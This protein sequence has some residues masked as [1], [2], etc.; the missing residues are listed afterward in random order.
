M[1]YAYEW[2]GKDN[3]FTI[4]RTRDT[5]R[6]CCLCLFGSSFL[7]TTNRCL[8][9]SFISYSSHQLWHA[10]FCLCSLL[11]S[12]SVNLGRLLC[13]VWFSLVWIGVWMIELSSAFLLTSLFDILLGLP[14]WWCCQNGG[15]DVETSSVLF[16]R[17]M[18]WKWCPSLLLLAV[19]I[20]PYS[21]VFFWGLNMDF[22]SYFIHTGSDI[23]ITNLY[24]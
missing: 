10:V 8:D 18:S 22:H 9:R 3:L 7:V 12:P 16:L 2:P 11:T 15:C 24:M 14:F 4:Q 6:K 5:A 20:T 19:L 23:F 21:A 17:M 1:V 13:T